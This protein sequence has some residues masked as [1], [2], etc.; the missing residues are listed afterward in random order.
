MKVIVDR[1]ACIGAASCVVIAL[2]TFMLD[3][4]GKAEMINVDGKVQNPD[5]SSGVIT[6]GN[7]AR[8]IVIE[9]ARS[10]PTNAIRVIEDDGTPV[11]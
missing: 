7:D 11:V 3:A 5:E 2:K 6:V 4:E 8:D 9:A 1:Q 10:C